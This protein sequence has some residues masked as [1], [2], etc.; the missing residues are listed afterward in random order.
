MMARTKEMEGIVEQK[1][2]WRYIPLGEWEA[3]LATLRKE[4]LLDG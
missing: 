3:D 2:F 1:G 4:G